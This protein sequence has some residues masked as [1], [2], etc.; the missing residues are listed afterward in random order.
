MNELLK[1]LLAVLMAILAWL[2]T[3]MPDEPPV[4]STTTSTTVPATSSTTV[5]STTTT[6]P[7]VTSTSTST[8]IPGTVE[9]GYR[10]TVYYIPLESN[11]TGG[12][13]VQISGCE[14]FCSPNQEKVLGSYRKEFLDAMKIE[15]SGVLTT[16]KYAGKSLNYWDNTYFIFNEPQSASGKPLVGMKTAA[17][18]VNLPYGA[19]FQINDCGTGV[20]SP[21]CSELKSIVWE[22]ND[23]F[24]Q[25]DTNR[26]VDLFLGVESAGVR[27]S[28]SK[29]Y[30]AWDKVK[31]KVS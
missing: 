29:F 5:T 6:K 9:S 12:N 27:G 7:P 18:T 30:I 17:A 16:G 1:Q 21:V 19:K 3:N 25:S 22:V 23:R 31:L 11:Y 2:Q 14:G 10:V 13:L 20:D 24:A 15:G 4:T 26:Q 8:T 28:Q